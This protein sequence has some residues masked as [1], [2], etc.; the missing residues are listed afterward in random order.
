MG[1][2]TSGHF[3]CFLGSCQGPLIAL[4]DLFLVKF[5]SVADSSADTMARSPRTLWAVIFQIP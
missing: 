1:L 4:S 5:A 3:C 2:L